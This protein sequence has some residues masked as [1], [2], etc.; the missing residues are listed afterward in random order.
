M[1]LVDRHR[2]AAALHIGAPSG[3]EPD[4]RSAPP[5]PVAEDRAPEGPGDV[6]RLLR[7]WR[8]GDPEAGDEVARIL[9]PELRWRA[10]LHLR[11]ER[12]DIT[13][14]ATEV[15]NEVFLRLMGSR[16]PCWEDRSHFL[17][18]AARLMR[19]VLVSRARHRGRRKRGS[20]TS[21]SVLH[22]EL[23]LPASGSEERI[24]VLALEQALERLQRIDGLAVRLVELRFFAGLSLDE[25]AV[26]LGTGRS[27]AVRRWRFA[28]AWI[29]QQMGERPPTEEAG[30]DGEARPSDPTRAAL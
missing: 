25:A 29:R 30:V 7:A 6:T 22:S 1:A 10:A 24:D 18:I 2:D 28:R 13:L 5:D 4:H 9:L 14:Q 11:R 19:Q 26:T 15:V 16:T 12:A 21:F 27:T 3:D 17:A 23:D 8:E 20:G